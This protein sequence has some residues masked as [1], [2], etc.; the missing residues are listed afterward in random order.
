MTAVTSAIG[1]G[2]TTGEGPSVSDSA[3]RARRGPYR[4]VYEVDKYS[5]Q[6][7]VVRI[8]HRADVY[9]PR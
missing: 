7:R 4:I 6:V 2:S 1:R 3:R 8:E 9:R 5:K